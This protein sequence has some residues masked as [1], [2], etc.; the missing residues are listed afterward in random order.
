MKNPKLRSGGFILILLF[1]VFAATSIFAQGSSDYVVKNVRVLDEPNDDGSGLQIQWEPLPKDKRIISYRIYR[2]INPDSLFFIGEIPVNVKTGVSSKIMSYY[3][4]SYNEFL[5]LRAPFKLKREKHQGDQKP[6]YFKSLPKD[7]NI[8][9][10]MLA[11]Y[12]ILGIIPKEEFYFKTKKTEIETPKKDNPK[13]KDK[14]VLAGLKINQIMLYKKLIPGEKYYYSIIAVDEKR[15]FHHGS[16]PIMGSPTDD[17]PEKPA[18][19]HGTYVKDDNRLQFEWNTPLAYDDL[20]LYRIYAIS[21]AQEAA[22]NNFLMNRFNPEFKG[23]NPAMLIYETQTPQPYNA[24]CYAIMKLDGT[25]VLNKKGI[26]VADLGAS[27]VENYKF[28]VSYTDYE[29]RET[30]SEPKAVP[31]IF[32][33]MLPIIP[34]LNVFDKP[35]DKGEYI[36]LSWGKPVAYINSAS[37]LDKDKKK[38]QLSYDFVTNKAH[39]INS[40]YFEV[41]DVKGNLIKTANEFYQDR[42]FK[43]SFKEPQHDTKELFVKM[44]FKYNGQLDKEYI[45]TQKLVYDPSILTLRP[46][47]VSVKDQQLEEYSAIVMKAPKSTELFRVIKKVSGLERETDD[48]IAYESVIYKGV[49]RYDAKKQLF[50]VD[51]NIDFIYDTKNKSALSTSIYLSEAGKVI[52]N[53]KKRIDNAMG[54]LKTNP[55]QKPAVDAFVA[56]VNKQI[57]AIKNNEFLKKANSFTSDKARMKYIAELREHDKREFTY[58]I[59]YT[60]GK[61]AIVENVKQLNDKNEINYFFPL[62]NWFNKDK[63]A[64]L[65]ASLLFGLLVF[66]YVGMAKRG[67]DLYIRPI[68]GIDEIDNAIGRATEMGRP[69]LFCPGLS[70]IGD[71][72]TLAGLS[73]LGRVAKK[74]A[75]YDTRILVPCRDYIVIPIAQEIVREAHYEAGRPD[76]FDKNNVFFVSDQQFAYVAGVNGV[77]IREKT[78]TNFYMGMFYAESLIMTETG[79]STGA[80]QIAGT[81]AVTQIPFFITT[82]DYTLIGEELYAASAYLARQPLML[83]TLKAQDYAKFLIFLFMVI[84]TILSTSHVTWIIKLFPN[85]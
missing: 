69:I 15:H 70:G 83:G 77:M 28:I 42:L 21:P 38:L 39:K 62:P 23:Q 11:K 7:I 30:F 52:D 3:D 31:V 13:E 29:N 82:C 20:N 54:M 33:N 17:Y 76:S 32:K 37:F 35:N 43:V 58:L 73:I 55:E 72:A 40:I 41:Y 75:E 81:D 24:P 84:G 57:D 51:T 1:L 68:A 56:N 8:V 2:G 6:Y 19:V 14:E 60:N 10:P 50:L 74:A 61:G 59:T 36:T 5:D 67:K 18:E 63:L 26:P 12:N 27:G 49:S 80:I 45:L 85:K 78:A 34:K 25:K 53:L 44:Y 47:K 4:K 65:I 22:F 66:I 46:S 71:V 9:G 16:K 79:N 48:K 64:A